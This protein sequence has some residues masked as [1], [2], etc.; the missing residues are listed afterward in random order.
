[1]GI[2]WSGEPYSLSVMHNKETSGR[3]E[4]ILDGEKIGNIDKIRVVLDLDSDKCGVALDMKDGSL[5]FLGPGGEPTI[6]YEA[7]GGGSIKGKLNNAHIAYAGQ[8]IGR[9]QSVDLQHR[10]DSP[11]TMITMKMSEYPAR[12]AE[13]CGS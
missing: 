5:R 12:V 4:V 3:W 11:L 10:A 13:V 8:Q 2:T 6:D 7:D 9:V 1:M